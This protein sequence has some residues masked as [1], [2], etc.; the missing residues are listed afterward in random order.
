MV[1]AAMSTRR[2]GANTAGSTIELCRRQ[3]GRAASVILVSPRRHQWHEQQHDENQSR[4]N[5]RSHRYLTQRNKPN[6]L[7]SR[8]CYQD[9]VIVRLDC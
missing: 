1:L 9:A 6:G 4:Q 3:G 7:L 2:A 5:Q 8:R